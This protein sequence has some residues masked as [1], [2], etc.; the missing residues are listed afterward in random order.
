MRIFYLYIVPGFAEVA[1]F[2]RVR[3]KA[4]SHESLPPSLP[5]EICSGRFRLTTAD[6]IFFVGV[7]VDVG[8][9]SCGLP[10]KSR[11][12]VRSVRVVVHTTPSGSVR[13]T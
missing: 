12:T 1:F 2:R 10:M 11:A 3:S 8:V 7:G 5:A 4:L 6:A 9:F 13:S